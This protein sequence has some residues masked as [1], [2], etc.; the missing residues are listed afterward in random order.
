MKLCS[1]IL[2][3]DLYIQRNLYLMEFSPSLTFANLARPSEFRSM[4]TSPLHT[5]FSRVSGNYQL[6]STSLCRCR[7][8]FCS[9]STSLS[10]ARDSY[11]R[12][13]RTV[14]RSFRTVPTTETNYFNYFIINYSSCSISVVTVSESDRA[15]CAS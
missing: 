13:Y 14:N 6:T 15:M 4:W 7:I 10:R 2:I 1:I 9:Q 3:F 5:D 8:K 11:Q 12:K